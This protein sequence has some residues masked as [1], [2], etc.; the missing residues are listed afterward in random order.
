MYVC[1]YKTNKQMYQ[2]IETHFHHFFIIDK[3]FSSFQVAIQS[4]TMIDGS[5]E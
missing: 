4:I 1:M 3:Y 5:N 2:N